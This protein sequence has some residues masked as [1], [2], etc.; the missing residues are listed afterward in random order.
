V[1]ARAKLLPMGLVE[2]CTLRRD[3]PR[4]TVLTYEDVEAPEG[5]LC[6]RLRR[7][8]DRHFLG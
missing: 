5:R 6:D 7:E 1:A 3:L 8:Q 4:D 2:S